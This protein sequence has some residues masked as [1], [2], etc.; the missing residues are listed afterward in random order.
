M[1]S[2]A[3]WLLLGLSAV[4]GDKGCVA[5]GSPRLWPVATWLLLGLVA[6]GGG[7]RGVA[8]GVSMV[9]KNTGDICRKIAFPEGQF[10][11]LFI[12]LNFDT[13]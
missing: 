2:I 1:G 7:E 12:I 9:L 4:G 8:G 3:T 13:N 11:L 10:L 5:G 6:A